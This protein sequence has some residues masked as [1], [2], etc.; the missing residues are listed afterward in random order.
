MWSFVLAE[1]T[2]L[3]KLGISTTITFFL[4][5]I[6]N[7]RT[8]GYGSQAQHIIVFYHINWP[9]ASCKTQFDWI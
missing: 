1:K 9:V 7:L 2:A 3:D 4:E 5:M 6:Y 8:L